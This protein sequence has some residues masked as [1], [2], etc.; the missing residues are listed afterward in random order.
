MRWV[1]TLKTILY[2][3]SIISPVIAIGPFIFRFHKIEGCH[4]CYYHYCNFSCD[5]ILGDVV[6]KNNNDLMLG[7]DAIRT[8]GE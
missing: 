6:V 2:S 4:N 3:S 5:N 1:F 7:D 8:N